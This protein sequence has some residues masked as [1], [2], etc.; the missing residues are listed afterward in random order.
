MWAAWLGSLGAGGMRG[1]WPQPHT[2]W[3]AQALRTE[4][5]SVP[6]EVGHWPHPVLTAWGG[7]DKRLCPRGAHIPEG[8]RHRQGFPSG[9]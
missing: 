8:K 2:S 6:T 1:T 7:D 5:A 3:S 4:P 9:P